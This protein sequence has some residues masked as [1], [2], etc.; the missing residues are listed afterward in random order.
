MYY[1]KLKYAD[2]PCVAF[3]INY[4]PNEIIKNNIT[5]ILLKNYQPKV[6]ADGILKLKQNYKQYK[7]NTKK[8]APELLERHSLKTP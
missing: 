7:H 5:G 3:D 6:M 4:G 2:Y 8:Y 1:L